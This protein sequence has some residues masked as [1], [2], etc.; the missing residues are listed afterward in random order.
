MRLELLCIFLP[1]YS[2]DYNPIENMFYKLKTQMKAIETD[3]A[4]S[5]LDSDTMLLTA[6]S[7]IEP[8]DCQNWIAG[9]GLYN[10]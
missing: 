4:S 6:L 2:P 8:Q 9:C 10:D 7:A 3:L 5:A 1:P